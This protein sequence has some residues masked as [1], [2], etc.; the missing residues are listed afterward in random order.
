MK[1]VTTSA[2]G[3]RRCT[4]CGD[5][6]LYMAY[7]DR[8][9]GFPQRNERRLFEKLCLEGFQ[10]GLSW[11]TILRKRENFRAAF[12]DFDFQRVARYGKRDVTR[13]LGDAG[14]VRHRGKIESAINNAKHALELVEEHGRLARY[15]ER[16]RLERP[17]RGWEPTSEGSK[18]LS[19]DLRA[20]GWSYVGPTTMHAFLQAVG[21]INDHAGGC[22][23]RAMAE[24][25]RQS[26]TP[27]RAATPRRKP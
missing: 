8:E 9:W 20:R 11:L 18:A 2:D 5:D 10:A 3:K 26:R 23:F 27:A 15:L 17:F 6:S 4:W 13:L 7:H 24:Q 16:Y 12:D 1:N 21:L 14:I 19:K 22:D 25:A